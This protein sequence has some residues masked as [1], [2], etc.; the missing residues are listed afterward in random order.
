MAAAVD[1]SMNLASLGLSPEQQE[2]VRRRLSP[3]IALHTLSHRE[4]YAG[5]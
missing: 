3:D 1:A 5:V 2:L 4:I